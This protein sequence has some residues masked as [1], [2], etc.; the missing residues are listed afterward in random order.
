ME[1]NFGEFTAKTFGKINF[2]EFV[3]LN[4]YN[5]IST[6]VAYDFSLKK[7][8]TFSKKNRILISS[9]MNWGVI[10]TSFS[11]LSQSV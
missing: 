8:Y 3:Q 1:V 10:C 9:V 4:F 2:G 11:N 5:V 6:Y 7:C